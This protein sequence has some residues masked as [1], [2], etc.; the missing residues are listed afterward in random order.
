MTKAAGLLQMH[1]GA[2]YK[3]VKRLGVA[4]P[5]GEAEA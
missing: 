3:L 5:A 2:I 4:I 1:R